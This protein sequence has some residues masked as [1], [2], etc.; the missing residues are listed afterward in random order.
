MLPGVS[1]AQKLMAENKISDKMIN[2]Q[3]AI[4]SSMT[5]KEKSDPDIIKVIDLS[6]RK[7]YIIDDYGNLVD[8]WISKDLENI[9]SPITA[10]GKG[11]RFLTADSQRNI[12]G[13]VDKYNLEGDDTPEFDAEEVSFGGLEDSNVKRTAMGD[14]LLQAKVDTMGKQTGYRMVKS[15]D[16]EDDFLLPESEE[17]LEEWLKSLKTVEDQ[18]AAYRYFEDTTKDPKRA[19]ATGRGLKVGLAEDVEKAGYIEAEKGSDPTRDLKIDEDDVELEEEVELWEIDGSDPKYWESRK[20][21]KPLAYE[22]II[23]ANNKANVKNINP[24]FFCNSIWFL[25]LNIKKPNSQPA[26]SSQL[27]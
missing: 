23:K 26:S 18:K 1:K 7:D 17:E 24:M 12:E 10:G 6:K 19:E 21:S 22:V 20:S 13:A 11:T 16:E 27:K 9:P 2:K 15:S 8:V 4:I 3:I 25:V 5:K 14:A